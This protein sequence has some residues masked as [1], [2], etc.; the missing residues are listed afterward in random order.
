M[1]IVLKSG[2]EKEQIDFLEEKIKKLG[3]KPYVSKGEFRTIIAVIGDEEKLRNEPIEAIDG[4][5]KV[6]PIMQPFKLVSKDFR[7]EKTVIRI[8]GQVIGGGEPVVMAGPCSVEEL[9]VMREIANKLKDIG[10]NFIRGGAF[11]PR[12]SPYSFQGLGKKGLEYLKIISDETGLP[13]VSEVMDPRDVELVANYVDILQIGTRNMQNFS[14][15]KEVGKIK[16]PILLKRG[17][18]ATI[19]EFLMAAEYILSNGNYNV[20]LCVRGIRTFEKYTRNTFDIDAIPFIKELSHL[21]VIA[22]PSHAIGIAK[23]VESASYAAIS[24]GADGLILESHIRPLEAKSDA[25]QTID[26]PTLKRI[27]KNVKKLK[28][29]LN[30][31]SD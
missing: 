21:P 7:P 6:L 2:T 11:K 29:L 16:K 31:Q 3:L 28:A 30:E 20:I 18:W 4:V 13:V 15:L 22:D 27:I 23:Y 24:I 1:I 25:K 9:D 12:T 8:K 26:I 10:V 14:L 19:E 5:E 17:M